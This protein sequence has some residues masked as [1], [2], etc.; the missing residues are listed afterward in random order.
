[1][2]E[3]IKHLQEEIEKERDRISSCSH[4][5]G[6]TFYNPETYKKPYGVRTIAHGSDVWS[7]PEGY[8]DAQ[9]PRWTRICSECGFEQNTYDQKPVVVKKYIPDFKE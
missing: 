5:W 9:K 2:N 8:E 4:K 1:M 6:N 3:R 7:E